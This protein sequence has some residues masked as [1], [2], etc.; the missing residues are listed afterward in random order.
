MET[1]TYSSKPKIAV[2]ILAGG[3]GSRLL[4]R[5]LPK[6]L[7]K[8]YDKYVI[9]YCLDIYQ[10]ICD[11]DHIVLVINEN[12]RTLFE[13]IVSDGNYTKVRKMVTGGRFRQNSVFNGIS[14]VDPCDFVIIQ[15]GVSIFTP[16]ELILE[17]IEKAKTHK[18][19]S[20]FVYEPYSSFMCID[21]K[22]K[23]ALDRSMLGHVRDPQVF[24]HTL[25]LRVHT[26]ANKKGMM[27]FTN[28]IFLLKKFGHEVYVVESNANNFKITTDMDIKLAEMIIKG[29]LRKYVL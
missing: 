25:L 29:G 24:D 23:T 10:N 16:Q 27:H 1:K 6:Q 17:C 2:V 18:V 28:D 11:I 8:I 5:N 7:I 15:N 26:E 9:S 19:V 20:A 3:V 12:F 13:K 4:S 14:S 21:N 22:I